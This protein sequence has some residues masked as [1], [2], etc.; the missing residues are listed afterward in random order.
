MLEISPAPLLA[1]VVGVFHTSLYVFVRGS[2]R[3]RL[4]LLL[5][6]AVLGAYGGQAVGLRLGDPLRVGDYG[7]L[8]SSV[9]AWVGIAVVAV[10]S[11]LGSPRGRT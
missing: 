8:W 1:I 4:L 11:L 5:P 6:A 9:L 7:L 3:G 10:V 2:A